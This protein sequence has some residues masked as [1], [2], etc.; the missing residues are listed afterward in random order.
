MIIIMVPDSPLSIP[1]LSPG[2]PRDWAAVRSHMNVTVTWSSCFGFGSASYLCWYSWCWVI[3][4]QFG[5]IFYIRYVI[6]LF[7]LLFIR[8]R[9]K[10]CLVCCACSNMYHKK[11]QGVLMGLRL[12]LHSCKQSKHVVLPPLTVSVFLNQSCSN[13]CVLGTELPSQSMKEQS[14]LDVKKKK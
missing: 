1:L 2:T 9:I 13:S 14:A 11:F 8:S 5:V 6:V 10:P 12:F 4:S 3:S 7:S